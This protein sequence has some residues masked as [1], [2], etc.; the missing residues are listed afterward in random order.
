MWLEGSQFQYCTG[1]V[2]GIEAG[3]KFISEEIVET[4]SK[5]YA[6]V[7]V[8]NWGNLVIIKWAVR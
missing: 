2:L 4:L 8:G 7:S 5:E 6:D 1:E 3:L